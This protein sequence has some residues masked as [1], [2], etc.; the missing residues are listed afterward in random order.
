[1]STE[2]VQA[3]ERKVHEASCQ[4]NQNL[5]FMIFI[6]YCITKKLCL[7]R[8]RHQVPGVDVPTNRNAV[9]L[10]TLQTGCDDA[11]LRDCG[12]FHGSVS[13]CPPKYYYFTAKLHDDAV[14]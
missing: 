6:L 3:T 12:H 5:R 9:H 4:P 8:F 13:G 2:A 10:Q 14:L 11:T 1:M 7:L